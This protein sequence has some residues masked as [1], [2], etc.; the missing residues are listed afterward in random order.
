VT[1]DCSPLPQQ[2][3]VTYY[4]SLSLISPPRVACVVL[5]RLCQQRHHIERYSGGGGGGGGGGVAE[6]ALLIA[7]Q[8]DVAALHPARKS[9]CRPNVRRGAT[10]V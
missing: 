2:L 9:L 4:N 1:R 8:K 3:Q 5:P 7:T 10:V 6:L